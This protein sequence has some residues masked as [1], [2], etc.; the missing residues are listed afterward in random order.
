MTELTYKYYMKLHL[1]ALSQNN[2][3][4]AEK[5]ATMCYNTKINY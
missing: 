3:G 1:V 2:F 4:L 5:I